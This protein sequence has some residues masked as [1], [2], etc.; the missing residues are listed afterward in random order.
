LRKPDDNRKCI[1]TAHK[2]QSNLPDFSDS[3][4][5]QLLLAPF[6]TN[7]KNPSGKSFNT[8]FH[9][10]YPANKINIFRQTNEYLLQSKKQDFPENTP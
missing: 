10:N 5:Q 2:K 4:N 8:N 1:I 6:A 3:T 7:K 9:R